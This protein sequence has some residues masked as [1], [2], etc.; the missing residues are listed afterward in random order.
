MS[1][2]ARRNISVC[3]GWSLFQKFSR[4]SSPL[5]KSASIKSRAVPTIIVVVLSITGWQL[6][7]V[8]MMWQLWQ[9]IEPGSSLAISCKSL[10][11]L[12]TCPRWCFHF[13]SRLSSIAKRGVHSK[14][15][16]SD[17]TCSATSHQNSSVS[18]PPAHLCGQTAH[19]AVMTCSH[20]SLQTSRIYAARLTI[21]QSL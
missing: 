16:L 4:S 13:Y 11:S 7:K 14:Q 17:N 5:E 6:P 10:Y 21:P 19:L 3:F 18:P 12:N 2:I 15:W 8:L 1:M 20:K 9:K